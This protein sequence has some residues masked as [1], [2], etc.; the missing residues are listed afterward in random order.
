MKPI[1]H[2]GRASLL[3]LLFAL[4]GCGG[5]S[6]DGSP[7]LAPLK[8][9]QA[10]SGASPGAASPATTQTFSEL[11]A[12]SAQINAQD[13]AQALEAQSSTPQD[14][15][16]A[17]AR[18][19]PISATQVFRFFNTLTE[20][21]FFTSSAAERDAVLAS[22]PYMQYNGPAFFS[23][24]QSET[25]LQPVYRFYNTQTGVHFYTISEQEKAYIQANFAQFKLEGAAYRASITPGVGLMP[26]YRF[27]FASKGFHFYTNNEAEVA[28]IRANLPQYTFEGVSYYVPNPNP[29]ATV[30]SPQGGEVPWNTPTT[31]AIAFSGPFGAPMASPPVCATSDASK[32]TVNADCSQVTVK[33]LDARDVVTVSS[34]GQ[35]AKL[36]LSSTPQ[37]HWS[38]SKGATDGYGMVVTADNRALI[39]SGSHSS[40]SQVLAQG[41][42]RG[43]QPYLTHPTPIKNMAGNGPLTD[44]V[45][46]SGG[47]G[48]ALAL[49]RNGS[50]WIW[51]SNDSCTAGTGRYSGEILLPVNVK[52]APGTAPL[53][54]V[55]QAETG[56]EN[57]VALLDDGRVM[58]WG[59]PTF[60]GVPTMR[61]LPTLVPGPNGAGVLTNIAQISAGESY[62]LALTQAGKVY[63]FGSDNLRGVLGSGT[64]TGYAD[65]NWPDTVKK[66][67]G[68]ELDNIVQ[69][70]AGYGNAM[71][72]DADGKVWIWGAGETNGIASYGK[73]ERIPYAAPIP[74][75]S[76]ITMVA[77]GGPRH[78]YALDSLG[79]I[80]SWAASG[81][82]GTLGDG[83]NNPRGIASSAPPYE[84]ARTPGTV[85]AENGGGPMTGALSIAASS[86]G[87]SA[88]MPD[89]RVLNWGTNTYAALGQGVDRE[90]SGLS[91]SLHYN[92]VPVPLRNE[93]NTGSMVLNPANYPNIRRRAR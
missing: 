73:K 88:L 28:S 16:K 17:G 1:K 51:G 53:T 36:S 52:D 69:V 61:C 64:L 35:T 4:S 91:W 30:V 25:T 62:Y 8:S 23:A 41:M 59:T 55:V 60:P 15:A 74:S 21:H 6:G 5:G 33:R 29:S 66:S 83:A 78:N 42:A 57:A 32:V 93:T 14:S 72:L 71:A 19:A 50:I 24:N 43:Q 65:K 79:Q 75:L 77:A 85:V 20:A 31:V 90:A 10:E 11:M 38:G 3:V 34:G 80:W 46:A 84:D 45:Q 67:D 68:S 86:S 82:D 56:A 40:Y 70:S 87:G 76:N 39:W 44:V 63:A 2:T 22:A 26:L 81:Q 27:Y 18:T 7:D 37:R 48:S 13:L 12:K 54:N 9:S 47:H 58:Y 49:S 89:G 92:Y